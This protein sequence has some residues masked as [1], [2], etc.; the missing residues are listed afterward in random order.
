MPHLKANHWYWNAMKEN[1]F[2][3]AQLHNFI[4]VFI[5]TYLFSLVKAKS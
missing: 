4:L 3:A 5:F 1:G 2:I